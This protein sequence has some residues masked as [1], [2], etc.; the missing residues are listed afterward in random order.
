[1]NR[2]DLAQAFF[3]ADHLPG[4]QALHVA[5]GVDHLV[6]VDDAPSIEIL[7]ATILGALGETARN[8]YKR[9][10]KIVIAI[11]FGCIFENLNSVIKQGRREFPATVGVV[12][13]P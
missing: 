11:S 3:V 6:F 1:M 12:S 7:A 9:F 8:P 10:Q 13:P 5:D 4:P 2:S